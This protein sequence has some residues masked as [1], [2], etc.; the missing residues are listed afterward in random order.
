MPCYFSYRGQMTQLREP[1]HG[2]PKKMDGC[3]FIPTCVNL[4]RRRVFFSS[5]VGLPSKPRNAFRQRAATLSHPDQQRESSSNLKPKAKLCA[6]RAR[7]RSTLG[8]GF[9]N[10]LASAYAE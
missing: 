6:G 8:G 3:V 7:K 5:A 10:E 9:F 4:G 1:D 2:R